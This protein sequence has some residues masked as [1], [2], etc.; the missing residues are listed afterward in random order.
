MLPPL[1]IDDVLPAIKVALASE[2]SAVIVAPPGAGKT[3]RVPLA[4]LDAAWLEDRKILVL[5]PRRL[6]A[7]GAAQQMARLLG[8]R[9]GD[10]VGIRARLG[11]VVGPRTRIEVVTEGVFVRMILDDP[12]LENVGAILFDEFH[13]RSLD[14]DLGLALAL[15]ARQGLREDLRLSVMSATL[16]AAIVS[17]LIGNAPVIESQGRMFPVATRY[18][19]RSVDMRIEDAI[20]AAIR[21]ALA[22]E[23]G[24]VL[25]FLPGQ[26]EIR[27]VAERLA[28]DLRDNM[29]DIAPLHAG[30]DL[31]DQDQ[32]VAPSPLG[33]RKVVLATSIA[34]TSLT[35]EGVRIVVDSG[36]QRSPRYDPEAGATR[37]VTERA[38]RAAV[39]QRRGRAGRI[40]P[41]VCYRLWDE[42]QD[43]S[44]L[45]FA[46][47]EIQIADLAPLLLATAAWGVLDPLQLSWLD[48]PPTARLAAARSELIELGALDRDGRLTPVGRGLG[49][50]A[51]P[52][53]LAAM[54]ITAARVDAA[55]LAAD[56][57]AVV[58]ERGL[59]GSDSDIT[60][61]MSR[62]RTD[63][64]RRANEMRRLAEAWAATATDIARDVDMTPPQSGARPGIAGV[65]MLAF[66]DRIAKA[67]GG[68]GQFLLANGRGAFVPETDP[69]AR[70]PFLV[71]AD[72]TGAAQQ[73]RITLAAALG[74]DE[75][76]GFAKHRIVEA[77]E[78]AF[79]ETAGALRTRR[80]LRIGAIVLAAEPRPLAHNE[81]SAA[82][83]AVAAAHHGID[84]LPWRPQQ[85]QLRARVAFLARTT[86]DQWPDL[87]DEALA[88]GTTEWLAPFLGEKS[89]LNDIS[90]DD[91][92][93]A[94]DALLTHAQMRRL[95]NEAPTHF[96][97]PTGMRHAIDYSASNAPLV[98]IK[99]QELFGLN[100]HPTIAGGRLALTLELLS[101]AGRPIQ[102]T[103]DLPGFWSGSWRDVRA[104]MRG[105]YPKHEWPE[106]PQNARPT[107][108]AKPR[109]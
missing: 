24:S 77:L 1:P 47:P 63:R 10:T 34:E 13:E 72:M 5:E 108:R 43:R 12:T 4:L 76:Y 58:V 36:L 98:A 86:P 97:A 61:R 8:E 83:L 103:R 78:T 64:S 6:A 33:R 92:S 15:D 22:A 107:I 73:S 28:A 48:P 79:D 62:F 89:A 7:R 59:G 50:L 14:A 96:E 26:A 3:T 20:S 30:L 23:D 40:E 27:R 32:A 42:P 11:T 109:R 52:P 44:L 80:V 19:G 68:A 84:R 85:V 71:V 102:V 82:A 99:V 90:G 25:A 67:R 65:L 41:G 57:A 104:A 2:R 87:G 55:R 49:R 100:Q 38:S 56:I 75:L 88:A 21:R 66:P 17:R 94:L 101:P 39:D 74:E 45:P 46:P 95:E 105:R 31:A 16:D 53:R 106:Q 18:L 54:V 81:Q 29:I 93:R 70:A 60:A 9:L 37:L 51:L 69:L 91:L 35:I